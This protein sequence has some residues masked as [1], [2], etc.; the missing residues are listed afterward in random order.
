MLF[1]IGKIAKTKLLLGLEQFRRRRL[2]ESLFCYI[3]VSL[4]RS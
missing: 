2:I 3:L 4:L 1:A